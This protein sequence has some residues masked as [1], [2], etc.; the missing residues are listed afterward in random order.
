MVALKLEYERLGNTMKYDEIS[1]LS[2]VMKAFLGVFQ[3]TSGIFRDN[4][5]RQEVVRIQ[6]EQ[7]QMYQFLS[8]QLME[9]DFSEGKNLGS[10]SNISE[11]ALDCDED[12]KALRQA[13]GQEKVGTPRVL[14]LIFGS[15]VESVELWKVIIAVA[16]SAPQLS[17]IM[18]SMATP[19]EEEM[20][21]SEILPSRGSEGKVSHWLSRV[22]ASFI[23]PAVGLMVLGVFA[24][25]AMRQSLAS[26]TAGDQSEI[27]Q[28]EFK[29]PELPANP[30]DELKAEIKKPVTVFKSKWGI[31]DLRP[32]QITL[33]VTNLNIGLWKI[34]QLGAVITKTVAS[35]PAGF[36]SIDKKIACNINLAT[37]VSTL[38]CAMAF[39]TS[40]SIVCTGKTNPDARCTIFL[41]LTFR[42]LALFPAAEN[43][44]SLFCP[45]ASLEQTVIQGGVRTFDAGQRRLLNSSF[46][47]FSDRELSEPMP[48]IEQVFCAWNV[49]Q[50][51]WFFA[52]IPPLADIARRRCPAKRGQEAA[53]SEVINNILTMTF[54]GAKFIAAATT[55]C[56][57]GMNVAAGCSA[58]SL[59]FMS[60]ITGISWVAS[61]FAN[62]ACTDL[63]AKRKAATE[64]RINRQIHKINAIK[65]NTLRRLLR[66]KKLTG[67][68]IAEA[69]QMIAQEEAD[70]RNNATTEEL[71]RHLMQQMPQETHEGQ[72]GHELDPYELL[73]SHLQGLKSPTEAEWQ[74]MM[75]KVRMMHD[76]YASSPVLA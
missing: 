6:Q 71:V 20:E 62:G 4:P 38:A 23:V 70:T 42:N 24:L 64:V 29:I 10:S 22:R 15:P 56:V 1:E 21:T 48:P 7:Y 74:Q 58:G 63:R 46:D 72:E 60:G 67:P 32:N 54:N 14:A 41:A 49:A 65:S 53:C 33:C 52:R 44:I 9:D 12:L 19:T 26:P 47:S 30:I 76:K 36:N 59:N 34:V 75:A 68:A 3:C 18:L 57:N 40:T 5:N 35:C 51:F 45:K 43:Q 11:G 8:H 13:C 61:A 16:I 17:T 55:N 39:F 73:L 28:Q 31:N 37:I 2:P 69:H 50:S 25:G 66:E 27:L